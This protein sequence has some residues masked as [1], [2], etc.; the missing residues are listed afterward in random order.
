MGHLGEQEH[1]GSYQIAKA[2]KLS[3]AVENSRGRDRE[4]KGKGMDGK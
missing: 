4:T 1:S 2:E 3:H